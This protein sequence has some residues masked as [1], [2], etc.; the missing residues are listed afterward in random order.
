MKYITLILLFLTG[1]NH[2]DYSDP[3]APTS[4][5][6]PKAGHGPCYLCDEDLAHLHPYFED[7]EGSNRFNDDAKSRALRI[8]KSSK[9][10]L[11]VDK[12]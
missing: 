2:C 5:S 7:I 1:C 8:I 3:H 10:H 6:C 4:H 12:R 9:N 11:M